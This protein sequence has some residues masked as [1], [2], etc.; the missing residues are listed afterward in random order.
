MDLI[1]TSDK[2]TRDLFTENWNKWESAIIKY[3]AASKNKPAPL[4][5]ALRDVDGDS[6]IYVKLMFIYGNVLLLCMLL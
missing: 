4:K 3:A 1:L 2:N 6:G 5:N